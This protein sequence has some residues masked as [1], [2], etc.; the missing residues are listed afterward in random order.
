MDD[1]FVGVV[2]TNKC[3]ASGFA[4]PEENTASRYFNRERLDH[5]R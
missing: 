4:S 1:P 5:G 3:R 2:S